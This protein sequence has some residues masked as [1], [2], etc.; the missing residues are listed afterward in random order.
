MK[1][2]ISNIDVVEKF[3]K[4]YN[5]WLNYLI[6]FINI[7]YMDEHGSVD[8]KKFCDHAKISPGFLTEILSGKKQPRGK[9]IIID[10]IIDKMRKSVPQKANEK[11]AAT[12]A[13]D[14]QNRNDDVVKALNNIAAICIEIKNVLEKG[15]GFTSSADRSTGESPPGPQNGRSVA[16]VDRHTP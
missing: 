10:G 4:E 15:Q 14:R 16:T 7:Y 2:P 13:S 12:G 8:R 5:W 3:G 6:D 1:G 11:S 9:K